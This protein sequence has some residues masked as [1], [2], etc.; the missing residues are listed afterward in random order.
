MLAA[1]ALRRCRES[2]G[3][4][5][6]IAMGSARDGTAWMWLRRKWSAPAQ[7]CPEWRPLSAANTWAA[8]SRSRVERAGSTEDGAGGGGEGRGMADGLVGVEER[9]EEGWED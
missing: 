8:P 1:E 7:S 3:S 9:W 6:A 2:D 5:K 4:S